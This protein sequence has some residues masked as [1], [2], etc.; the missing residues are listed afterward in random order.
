VLFVLGLSVLF[1]AFPAAYLYMMLRER[2][3]LERLFRR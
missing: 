3:L 2:N 1:L